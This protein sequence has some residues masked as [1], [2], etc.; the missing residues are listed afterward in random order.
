MRLGQ[1]ASV[2]GLCRLHACVTQARADP[3]EVY[4]ASVEQ[5]SGVTVAGIVKP[6]VRR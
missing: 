1:N 2:Y 5:R 3:R 6:H 4:V